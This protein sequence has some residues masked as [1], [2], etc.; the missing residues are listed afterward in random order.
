MLVKIHDSYR[1][2]VAICDS[3]LIGKKFVSGEEKLQLD[4]TGDFFKG[5]EK[6]EEE[7]RDLIELQLGEDATFNVVGE[8]SCSLAVDCGL[9]TK[10]ALIRIDDV[11]VGLVLL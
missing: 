1:N 4:L 2:V 3:D 7:L 9:F 11:P 8:N 5:E 10:D 6:S